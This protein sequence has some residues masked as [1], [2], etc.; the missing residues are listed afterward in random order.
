MVGD[1]ICTCITWVVVRRRA[2]DQNNNEFTDETPLGRSRG[3]YITCLI[4]RHRFC[5]YPAAEPSFS[6]NLCEALLRHLSS[7]VTFVVHTGSRSFY[8]RNISCFILLSCH[9][10]ALFSAALCAS[11]SSIAFPQSFLPVSTYLLDT[12]SYSTRG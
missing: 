3:L 8:Y 10:R 12:R 1:L 5:F 2:I 6:L 9:L 11:S 4:F 7:C